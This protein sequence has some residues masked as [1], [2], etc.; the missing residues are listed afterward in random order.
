MKS[1]SFILGLILVS[2]VLAGCDGDS[3]TNTNPFVGGEQGLAV[4]YRPLYPPEEVF[5]CGDDVFDVEVILNNQGEYDIK[6]G[7]AIVT[8]SG[9]LPSDR[10]ILSCIRKIK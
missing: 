8:L 9:I 6:Q 7:E 4:S 2:L 3:S 5:D 1:K 10:I